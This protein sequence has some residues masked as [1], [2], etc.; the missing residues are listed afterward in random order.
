MRKKF[1]VVTST[2]LV[3]I[4]LA[5]FGTFLVIPYLTLFL[6]NEFDYSGVQIGAIL[7]T[8]AFSGLLMSFFVGPYIDKFPKNKVILTG[9][10]GYLACY[11]YFPF[12]DQYVGFIVFAVLLGMS[13]SIVEPTYR[14]LLSLYTEPENRRLIFNIRYFLI[15]ISAAVAPLTSVYFQRFGLENIFFGVG[16]IFLVNIITFMVLFKKYPMEIPAASSSK[17]SIFQSFHVFK[18]DYAFSIFVLALIFITFGYSQFDSTF[19]Q[20]LGKTFDAELAVTYFS[21]LITTNAITVLIIQYF[22]YKLGERIS[23]TSSLMIG[24]GMLSIG[25]L[26]FGQS[27]NIIVLI[28]AMIIF[29]AGEVL[30][31]TMVDIHI[32]SMCEDHEKGTYF[33]LTGVKS[34]GRIIGPSLGG[35]L[36]DNVGSG[37]AVFFIISFITILSVPSFFISSKMKPRI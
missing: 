30:V 5:R 4:F 23:T 26:I 33:A 34:V 19:S 15:N 31:F 7:S 14:V 29:T 12:I 24:S 9:L 32:D 20:Y 25:L 1:N 2:I 11:I 21:W 16:F 28:V 36:L 18:K 37:A 22:V 6:L 3:S 35:I 17:S 8:L 13:Q 27:P 10:S